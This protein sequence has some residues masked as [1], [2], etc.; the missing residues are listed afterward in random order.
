MYRVPAASEAIGYPWQLG[1]V[2]WIFKVEMASVLRTT[3]S[4]CSAQ[5]PP[6]PAPRLSVMYRLPL[7]SSA[8]QEGYRLAWVASPPADAGLLPPPAMVSI[9]PVAKTTRR[10]RPL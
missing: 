3:L 9:R 6:C 4:T 10:I 5:L 8:L 1:V 2:A 7:P